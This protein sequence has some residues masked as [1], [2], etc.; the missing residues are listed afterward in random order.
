MAVKAPHHALVGAVLPVFVD[1]FIPP[2][3][4]SLLIHITP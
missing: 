2:Y 1:T 3:H 4:L